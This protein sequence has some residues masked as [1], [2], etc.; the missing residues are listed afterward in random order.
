MLYFILVLVS[1]TDLIGPQFYFGSL[2]RDVA[3]GYRPEILWL[4]IVFWFLTICIHLA[5]VL[6]EDGHL[7]KQIAA[8]AQAEEKQIIEAILQ[9]LDQAEKRKHDTSHLEDN[10]MTRSDASIAFSQVESEEHA[11]HATL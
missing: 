9:R 1:V 2:F 4:P 11:R 10:S 3:R 8:R 7:N 5:S 6:I